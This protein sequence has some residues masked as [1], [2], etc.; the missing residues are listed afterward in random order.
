MR[1]GCRFGD[2]GFMK[3]KHSVFAAISLWLLLGYS[4][5]IAAQAFIIVIGMDHV[6]QDGNAA[7]LPEL[8]QGEILP[9]PG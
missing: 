4:G 1:V 2:G 9:N 7:V 6:G 5:P 3:V 8:F